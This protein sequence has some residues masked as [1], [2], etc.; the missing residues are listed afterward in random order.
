L[1]EGRLPPRVMGL[2]LEWAASHQ[3]ELKDNWDLAAARKPLRSIAP[4]Q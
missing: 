4:L 2:V 1:L 3:G